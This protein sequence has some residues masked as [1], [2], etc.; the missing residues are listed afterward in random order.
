MGRSAAK[1][2]QETK[3]GGVQQPEPAEVLWLTAGRVS[4][5][6]RDRRF[7]DAVAEC[8][9]ALTRQSPMFTPG[10][11]VT[12][13]R[14]QFM[15]EG[16]L[17]ER[18]RKFLDGF[19][20]YFLAKHPPELRQRFLRAI[21]DDISAPQN[22][23]LVSPSSGYITETPS[24][25]AAAPS[26][27]PM[28]ETETINAFAARKGMTV[29]QLEEA[30]DNWK[31]THG[32][33]AGRETADRATAEPRLKWERDRLPDENPAAF[34][35]RAYQAEAKAGTLHRGVIAQ[36]DKSLAVKLA[37][38]LRSHPMPDGIDIPTLP[39]WN[40]RQLA[41]LK[42]EAARDVLRLYEVAKKRKGKLATF[43][44]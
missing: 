19:Y 11:F 28:A 15:Q 38:W 30:A 10:Q 25:E 35:W 43:A 33:V 34:A 40:T 13:I 31:A 9:A 29:A 6:L 32:E 21:K 1:L 12:A 14:R 20:S 39:E 37:S 4:K 18:D 44:M 2:R 22:S 8:G 42:G 17:S 16:R 27:L 24:P 26:Q 3:T 41:K 23:D 36:E 7:D 5:L